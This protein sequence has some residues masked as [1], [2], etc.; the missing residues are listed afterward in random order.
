MDYLFVKHKTNDCDRFLHG[1]KTLAL[2]LVPRE[3][4]EPSCCGFSYKLGSG[5]FEMHIYD[6]VAAFRGTQGCSFIWGG[7]EKEID[8]HFIILFTLSTTRGFIY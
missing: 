5:S 3:S 6:S 8:T 2:S 1:T 4:L 7:G